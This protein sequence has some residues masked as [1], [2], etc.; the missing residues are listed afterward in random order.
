LGD[1]SHRGDELEMR[2]LQVWRKMRR[3]RSRSNS[4]WVLAWLSLAVTGG[5]ADARFYKIPANQPWPDEW[6]AGERNPAYRKLAL[7]PKTIEWHQQIDPLALASRVDD[8]LRNR[9]PVYYYQ[10]VDYAPQLRNEEDESRSLPIVE[11]KLDATFLAMPKPPALLTV[12]W[13]ERPFAEVLSELSS[14]LGKTIEVADGVTVPTMV[15]RYV[16]EE[17]PRRVLA[18]LLLDHDLFF[19]PVV[20]AAQE[21]RS[22]EFR[23]EVMFLGALRKAAN[24]IEAA[25]PNGGP[26]TVVNFSD[27]LREN[28]GVRRV[29]WQIDEKGEPQP[30]SLNL[31]NDPEQAKIHLRQILRDKIR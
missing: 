18:E 16:R 25:Y 22:F 8:M 12:E 2:M 23:S 6:V 26:L 29:I 9:P 7:S 14:A 11:V 1:A 4:T 31:S 24:D 10:R 3:V 19:E 17:D 20:S 5:C 28:R 30:V 21:I 13:V 15:T 27:W